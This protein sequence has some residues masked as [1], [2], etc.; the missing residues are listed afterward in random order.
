MF[1]ILFVII[2]V[3]IFQ[4]LSHIFENNALELIL[5]YVKVKETKEARLAFEALKYL[6][7]LLCHKKF[8]IDFIQC[9]GVEVIYQKLNFCFALIL[10]VDIT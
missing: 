2:K 9:R 3:Y 6:A 1:K 4:F 8:S 10:F 7:S 5:S